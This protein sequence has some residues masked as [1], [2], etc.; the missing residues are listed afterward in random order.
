MVEVIR[1]KGKAMRNTIGL[2][3]ILTVVLFAVSPAKRTGTT[4]E[5]MITC[6]Q[7]PGDGLKAR[8]VGFCAA[9]NGDLYAVYAQTESSSPYT[10]E[11]YFSKSTDGWITWNGNSG[12]I[13]IDSG[14][15]PNIIG[16]LIGRD[17]IFI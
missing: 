12:S 11:L 1:P 14:L 3:T 8:I 7:P 5:Q 2:A 15:S 10:R 9:P 16:F 17:P 6:E 4:S 13:Y